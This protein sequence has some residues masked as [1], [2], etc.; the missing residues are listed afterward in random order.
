[1]TGYEHLILPKDKFWLLT[2][3]AEISLYQF[4]QGIAKHYFC[5]VCGIKSFYVPRSNPDGVSVNFRCVD[6]ARFNSIKRSTFDGDNFEANA[7]LLSH[8]SKG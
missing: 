8:L 7:S 5:A 4:N 2:S 6:K 1:M 3:E